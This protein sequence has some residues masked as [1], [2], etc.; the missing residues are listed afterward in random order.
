MRRL[1]PAISLALTT[2]PAWADGVS[3]T[4]SLAAPDALEVSYELPAACR[5]LP[6]LKDGPDAQTIRSRWQPLSD[7][8][9]AGGDTLTRSAASCPQLRFRVPATT[10]KV[11]GYPGSFPAGQAIY[12]HMS[13]YAVGPQCGPVRYR[14][15]APGSIETARTR[16]EQD[17]PADGDAPALLFPARLAADR[18]DLDYFDP[19]LSTVAVGQIRTVADGTASFLQAAMPKAVFKRPIIAATLAVEP[20]GPNIGGNAGDLLLLSLFNWPQQPAPQYQ[21]LMNKLVAHEMSHR[22]QLRDAVEVYPDARLINEGGAEFLRWTISL[23]QGWLTPQQ[24]AQELDDALAD[25]MLGTGSRSWRELSQREIGGAHLEYTCGLPAY[26]YAM[27]AR[28]GKGTPYARMDEFYQ[29]LRNGAQPDFAQAMECGPAP[30]TPRVLPAIL[31]QGRP[32]REQWAAVLAQTGLATPRA[33]T[34]SQTDAMM[35]QAVTQLVRED[36]GG[37]RSMTPTPET[38]LVYTLPSCA[39]VRAD[40]EVVQVEG[41]PLFGGSAALPAIVDA[42]AKRHSVQLGLKQGAR[43]DV[44]C[45]APYEVTRHMYAADMDKITRALARPD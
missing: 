26:V 38:I 30:C 2:V 24:A 12:A 44:A 10:D 4:V 19:A 20:G 25:C 34:Q 15:A 9:S 43:L 39:S 37:K 17:A 22:F 23:R 16:F 36:C 35:L 8:G 5:Q 21:R 29:Q 42:C 45:R 32:M 40:I 18:K 14:Y 7:C 28:Q 31:G 13:N 33:P 3:V 11:S 27:A 6:F 1:L 41:L